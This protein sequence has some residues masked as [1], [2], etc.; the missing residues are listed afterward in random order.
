[1]R[2]C[3]VLLE[4]IWHVWVISMGDLLFCEQ[5]QEEWIWVAQKEWGGEEKLGREKRGETVARINNKQRGKKEKK[6]IIGCL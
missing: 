3:L 2:K 1:M 5:E 6:K 4:L